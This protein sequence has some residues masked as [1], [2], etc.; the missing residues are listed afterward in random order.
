MSLAKIRQFSHEIAEVFKI[1]PPTPGDP[2]E[3]TQ[4]YGVNPQMYAPLGLPWHNGYDFRAR[5]KTKVYAVCDGTITQVENGDVNDTTK[6][7][8]IYYETSPIM[9]KDGRIITLEFLYFHLW[10]GFGRVGDKVKAKQ[11]LGLADNTGT[12]S[13]AS[14]LHFGVYAKQNGRRLNNTYD[15]CYGALDPE[16]LINW[17]DTIMKLYKNSLEPNS[18]AVYQKGKTKFHPIVYE[19]FAKEMYGDWKDIQVDNVAIPESQI[20]FPIGFYLN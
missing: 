17:Q 5:M 10:E 11:V 12:F 14:H 1:N 6:G 4:M 7:R 16:P 15:M 13:T 18:K 20:G 8:Y 2:V 19:R 3:T 9:L